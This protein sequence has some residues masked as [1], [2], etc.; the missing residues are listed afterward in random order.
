MSQ[1]QSRTNTRTR[2]SPAE[3]GPSV[4]YEAREW[5]KSLL[6]PLSALPEPPE[7]FRRKDSDVSEKISQS[8][9]TQLCEC[10]ILEKAGRD[11][12]D[13]HYWRLT[14]AG[15]QLIAEL[16]SQRETEGMPCCDLR[17]VAWQ[18]VGDPQVDA[19][20]YACKNELCDATYSREEIERLR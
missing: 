17:R 9:L 10:G 15:A 1:E 4:S 18:T 5:V 8:A 2:Y 20:P 14:E 19:K 12:M 16:E 13:V 7:T 3:D 11:E 6:G